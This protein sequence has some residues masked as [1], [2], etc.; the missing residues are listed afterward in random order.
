MW[1]MQRDSCAESSFIL[2]MIQRSADITLD[3]L[4][5]LEAAINSLGDFPEMGTIPR[6][7]VLRRKGYRVLLA[8]RHLVFYKIDE[9]KK[10]VTIHA[11]LDKRREYV[12]L[13]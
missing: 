13:V 8:E 5:K 4:E 3:Y 9:S 6:Y 1:A 2:Q 12:N 10:E 7:E 11:I